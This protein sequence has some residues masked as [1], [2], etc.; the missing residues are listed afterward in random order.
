MWGAGLWDGAALL[1]VH[2]APLSAV[3]SAAPADGGGRFV[4]QAGAVNSWGSSHVQAPPGEVG[5]GVCMWSWHLGTVT[6]ALSVASKPK[7]ALWL[8]VTADD[9]WEARKPWR[10]ADPCCCLFSR[11]LETCQHLVWELELGVGVRSQEV[12]GSSHR[13]PGGQF[14]VWAGSFCGLR[15]PV[16]RSSWLPDGY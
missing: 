13:V 14:C 8:F 11:W 16:Q 2:C 12:G 1:W 7:S 9:S 3:G 4:P 6:R 5:R 15:F 10:L